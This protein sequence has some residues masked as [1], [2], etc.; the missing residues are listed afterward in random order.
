MIRKNFVY[1]ANGLGV[2]LL[3]FLF[4]YLLLG[5]SEVHLFEFYLYFFKLEL[6]KSENVFVTSLLR[7]VLTNIFIYSQLNLRQFKIDRSLQSFNY[8]FNKKQ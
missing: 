8:L 4:T 5:G 1:I 2:C 3:L 7:T 6:K